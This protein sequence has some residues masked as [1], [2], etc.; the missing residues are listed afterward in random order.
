MHYRHTMSL[1]WNIMKWALL[2]MPPSLQ[3]GSKLDTQQRRFIAV[4]AGWRKR[5]GETAGIVPWSIEWWKGH[6]I[7]WHSL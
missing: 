3:L 6:V 2:I 1:V 5:A 7:L 4:M